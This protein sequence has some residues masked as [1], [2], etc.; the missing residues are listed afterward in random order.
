MMFFNCQ[1]AWHELGE[2][3]IPIQQSLRDTYAW[4]KAH[5]DV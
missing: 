1:Q 3:Q 4:Y 5:G 2:P